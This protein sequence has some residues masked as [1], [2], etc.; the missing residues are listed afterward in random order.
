MPS[1]ITAAVCRSFN[2]PLTLETLTLRDPGPG[3][4]EVTVEAVAICHSDISYI[5]GAW[6]GDLP[7]VF[8]H[9]AVGR[10]T[11]LGEGVSGYGPGDRV[12]VTLIRSC[13]ACPTCLQNLPPYCSGNI[14]R[15]P[16]LTD[17]NGA[18]VQKA[19]NCGAFAEKVIVDPSQIA[20]LPDTIAPQ[21]ACLLACGVPTG[22]GAVVNTARVRPGE[23]VVVIGAGG[24]GLNV[25]QGARLAGAA[26]IV[27]MDLNPG[28][29]DDAMAFGATD[30]VPADDPKPWKA[31][32]AATFGRGAD[33]VFVSV[34][35]L[36]AYDMA[37][38]LL[39]P[40]GTAYAVGMPHSGDTTPYEPV[41]LAALGQ[42][43]RGTKMGD[44][45][46]GRDI[47]WMLS[48]YE[49]GRLKLDELISRSWSLD[50]INQAIADTKT[51]AA[52]RNVITF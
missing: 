32:R 10:I 17:R 38:R 43:I 33:H 28:K 12:L 11:A 8:G 20:P 41:I 15:P 18:P 39:A 24:V 40:M 23:T 44:V 27:A 51:G 50:Q 9:E 35:A 37:P 34:G 49:Q 13:G 45:V 48:L 30:W 14:P 25:I 26:R 31:V 52:R 7:M 42:G 36:P 2:A 19:M 6:G 47:P 5:D 21:A 1:T 22:V 16:V 29:R 46:L 3:E 4:V